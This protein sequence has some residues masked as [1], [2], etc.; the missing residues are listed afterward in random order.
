[1][2]KVVSSSCNNRG[3]GLELTNVSSSTTYNGSRGF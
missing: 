1:M 3:Y 2:K